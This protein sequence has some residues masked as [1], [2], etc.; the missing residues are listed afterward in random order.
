MGER[1]RGRIGTAEGVKTVR[2]Y[3]ANPKTADGYNTFIFRRDIARSLSKLAWAPIVELSD[4]SLPIG[5]LR[6]DGSH[7]YSQE[8]KEA[9]R[10]LV[11]ELA[12]RQK[13]PLANDD[14]GAISIARD[15]V[16]E[17]QLHAIRSR[18]EIAAVSAARRIASTMVHFCGSPNEELRRKNGVRF[19]EYGLQRVRLNADIYL[20]LG[21]VGVKANSSPYY[22]QRI[23]AKFKADSEAPSLH[24]HLHIGESAFE[25]IYD[26]RFRLILQ[27]VELYY[28]KMVEYAV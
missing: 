20:V 4:C 14:F 24:G 26:N 17:S 12:N 21:E 13:G 9:V 2:V 16:K 22:D 27:G 18:V 28:Q 1:T 15:F 3:S 8:E 11:V 5:T 7:A 25:R 6:S 19:F 23:V 10:A